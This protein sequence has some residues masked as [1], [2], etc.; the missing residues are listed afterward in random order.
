MA[1]FGNSGREESSYSVLSPKEIIPLPK[2]S[3][4][5]QGKQNWKKY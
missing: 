4:V 3:F 2:Q 5:K 1:M